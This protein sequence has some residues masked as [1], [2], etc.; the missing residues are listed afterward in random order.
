MQNLSHSNVIVGT[1]IHGLGYVNVQLTTAEEHC[2]LTKDVI[3][4]SVNKSIESCQ[5]FTVYS[6]K[7][8][9]GRPA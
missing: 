2:L 1:P 9:S 6:T 4:S 7:Y 3:G 8:Q 5:W